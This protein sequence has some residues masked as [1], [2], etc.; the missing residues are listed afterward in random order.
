MATTIIPTHSPDTPHRDS[1]T[2]VHLF[3]IYATK[4]AGPTRQPYVTTAVD[5]VSRF[6]TS[7]VRLTT[8]AP[9]T[10]STS[11]VTP[12][13]RLTTSRPSPTPPPVPVNTPKK[14]PS[15]T[16]PVTT[17]PPTYRISTPRLTSQEGVQDVNF[18]AIAL[19]I[20][21]V[22]SYVVFIFVYLRR[23]RPNR[24]GRKTN[25]AELKESTFSPSPHLSKL[26]ILA[27]T[28]TIGVPHGKEAQLHQPNRPQ[29][30]EG[31]YTSLLP[32]NQ[33]ADGDR[34]ILKAALA[35]HWSNRKAGQLEDTPESDGYEIVKTARPSPVPIG[36]VRQT[37]QRTEDDGYEN[38]KTIRPIPVPKLMARPVMK[39]GDNDGYENTKRTRPI[40][41]PQRMGHKSG[42]GQDDDEDDDYELVQTGKEKPKPKPKPIFRCKQTYF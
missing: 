29:V 26:K 20:I 33:P 37:G 7:K 8:S 40:P 30:E 35:T 1:P 23:R 6:A 34:G 32:V 41:M 14:P 11:S 22:L 18:V 4:R 3:S 19:G 42:K 10:L 12:P 5:S 28:K 27:E 16:Y 21:L 31:G 38:T 13:S 17:I 15:S 9:S 25:D 24:L 2:T 36:K 39:A